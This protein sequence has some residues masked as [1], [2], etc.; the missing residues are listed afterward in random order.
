MKKCTLLCLG[1]F[2]TVL[3]FSQNKKSN[4]VALSIPILYNQSDAVFYS[5]GRRKT[6]S[7]DAFSYGINVNYSK[8]I[9]KNFFATVGGG[10]FKQVFGIRRPF[11]YI[12]PDGSKPLISTT[13]YSYR[14]VH[15]F[16]GLGHKIKLNN[17]YCLNN[18]LSYNLYHTYNQNYKQ[19]YFPNHNPTFKQRFNLGSIVMLSTGIEKKIAK[20]VCIGLDV[21][22]PI[23]TQWSY[24]NKFN[25]SGY[26]ID[27]VQIAKNKFSV[28]TNFSFKYN[29]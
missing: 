9:Y 4:S 26:S 13:F 11:N 3:L 10:Y 7:G 2:Y 29:F 25:G 21:L 8:F 20:N 5:L 18:V 23:K 22:V 1:I 24:D 17:K 14:N 15:S 12:P 6:T 27:E 19:N 28:G 16:V